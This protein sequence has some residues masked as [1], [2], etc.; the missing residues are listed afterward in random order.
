MKLKIVVIDDNDKVL[1]KH[2]VSLNGNNNG[3]GRPPDEKMTD[4]Q[5]RYIFRILASGG[6]E[7]ERAR[8]TIMDHL[9]VKDVKD[10]TKA[11]ASWLIEKLKNDI[12]RWNQ[13][14]RE[15]GGDHGSPQ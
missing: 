2:E 13:K 10:V 8:T 3:P 4:A 9:A 14:P 15:K 7:G 5:R 12:E 11:Q 1:G 6:I